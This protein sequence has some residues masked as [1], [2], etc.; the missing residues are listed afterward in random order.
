MFQAF[1][2]ENNTSFAN[3]LVGGFVSAI[4]LTLGIF[5][6]VKAN[7]EIRKITLGENDERQE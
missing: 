4:I 6:I 3:G 2:P 7:K 5:M 1:S